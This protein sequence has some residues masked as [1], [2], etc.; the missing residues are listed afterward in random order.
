V[1]PTAVTGIARTEQ[2][3]V[4]S[5]AFAFTVTGGSGSSVALVPNLL[6]MV[7]GDTHT[8]EALGSNG[9]SMTGL[10]W[11]SSAPT[12][13]SLSTA[14]PPLLTALAAGHVTLTAGGASADVTVSAGALPLGTVLW[15]NPGNGCVSSIVPAVPSTNGIADV[16]AF[17]CDNTRVQA[18]TSDGTTAWTA[19]V[20]QAQWVMPDFQGGLV[21]LIPVGTQYPHGAIVKLDGITGQPGAVYTPTGTSYLKTSSTTGPYLS[22]HTDGTVFA[23]VSHNPD[24]T[25]F[26]IAP[27]EVIGVDPTTGTQKFSVP[28][29]RGADDVE[30]EEYELIVAGD[31]YAYVTYAYRDGAFPNEHGHLM[32]LRVNSSGAHND[33]HIFDWAGGAGDTITHDVPIITNADQGT[34]LAWNVAQE[35]GGQLFGMATVTGTSVNVISGPLVAGQTG[36]VGPMLQAQDGSFVGT[37]TTNTGARYMIAFDA[38]GNVRWSVPNESPQ[39]A[40]ADGG[41][42]GQSGITYDQNGNAVGQIPSRFQSWRGYTY[43]IGSVNQILAPTISRTVLPIA[44]AAVV[45]PPTLTQINQAKG[46]MP[47]VLTEAKRVLNTFQACKML[48]GNDGSRAGD[49]NPPTVLDALYANIGTLFP[50]VNMVGG[51]PVSSSFVWSWSE[52]ANEAT[53]GNTWY[54]G[55]LLGF[56]F[57]PK[58]WLNISNWNAEGT[59]GNLKPMVA[60]LLHEMGHVYYLLL[61]GSGGSTIVQD[62]GNPVESAENDQRVYRACYP[63]P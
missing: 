8:I 2:N 7:V 34:L 47:M 55:G 61:P 40:T 35:V 6:N 19:D 50:T 17:P 39:I 54:I 11:T 1:S 3:G 62:R 13:V 46:Y 44:F 27:D 24:P 53:A 45:P 12:V 26:Y 31:G 52:D 25:T 21:K 56:R 30:Q 18:I 33:I 59:A 51:K 14:D 10:T 22:V 49:Y 63:N 60:T 16:F 48:F 43:E 15:S 9:Q 42:I 23:I 58:V 29:T 57:G 36:P 5:K 20:S 37:A 41:V 32:L 38:S 4:W 28:L